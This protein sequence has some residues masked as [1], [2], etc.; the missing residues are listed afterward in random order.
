MAH[1]LGL[2]PFAC[3]ADLGRERIFL[4]PFLS[5]ATLVHSRPPWLEQP[6]PDNPRW[7]SPPA[8]GLR[9]YADLF[10]PRQIMTLSTLVDLLSEVGKRLTAADSG[11]ADYAQAVQT[12]RL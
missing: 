12:Y 10:C 6:M 11:N 2:I 1:G 3:V 9:T 5:A 7:F 4:N 8:Y